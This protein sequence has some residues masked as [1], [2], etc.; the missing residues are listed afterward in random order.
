M[1]TTGH[2]IPKSVLIVSDNPDR[3]ARVREGLPE[4]VDIHEIKV[5]SSSAILSEIALTDPDLLIVAVRIA[6]ADLLELIDRI[7]HLKSLPAM[8][9]VDA[10]EGGFAR[11][12]IRMG[13]CSFIVDG[14]VP[15]RIAS[16]IDVAAERFNLT[17]ALTTELQKSK[18]SLASRKAV[19]RAKGLLMTSRGITEQEAYSALRTMAMRQGK[20]LKH[21]S[22]TLI[23]M[24]NADTSI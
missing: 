9:F 8:V 15:S 11:Q 10:D 19:E 7:M 14:L 24:T 17:I 12:A 3:T 21:I 16:L 1:H 4:T 22:D 20:S 6:S 5:G 13:V 2:F 18:D 23:S